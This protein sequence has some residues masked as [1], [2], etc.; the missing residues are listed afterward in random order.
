MI[1]CCADWT[2]AAWWAKS[3]RPTMLHDRHVHLVQVRYIVLKLYSGTERPTMLHDR[4]LHLVQ[5]RYIVL[6]FYSAPTQHIGHMYHTTHWT[7]A[8][9]HRIYHTAS[10]HILSPS[11]GEAFQWLED[12]TISFWSQRHLQ[13]QIRQGGLNAPPQPIREID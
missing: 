12:T 8:D 1:G 11:Q 3:E 13:S 2:A 4:H 9:L 6:K 7:Q 5:V 10:E